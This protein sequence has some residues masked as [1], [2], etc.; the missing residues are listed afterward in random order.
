MYTCV[1][2]CVLTLSFL[3]DVR[4][5]VDWIAPPV[6]PPTS[7]PL[8]K[9]LIVCGESKPESLLERLMESLY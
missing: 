5:E 1:C 4:E 7:V 9:G 2:I 3:G 8:G 6:A